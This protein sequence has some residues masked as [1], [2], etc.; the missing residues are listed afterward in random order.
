MSR[1]VLA[2]GLDLRGRRPAS[3]RLRQRPAGPRHP[4]GRAARAGRRPRRVRHGRAGAS[5]TGRALR[6]APRHPGARTA[7]EAGRGLGRA[8]RPAQ[9]RGKGPDA[10]LARRPLVARRDRGSRERR[11]AHGLRPLGAPPE[12]GPRRPR[13]AAASGGAPAQ[14]V[15]RPRRR[16]ARDQGLRR[17]GRPRAL[18]GL[19]PRSRDPGAGRG[20][21]AA[22]RALASP[23]SRATAKASSQSAR[24]SSSC[25][26]STA[27]P[28][29]W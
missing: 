8:A 10:A 23:G 12:P 7:V 18:D 3:L 1:R 5:R 24:P 14:L 15:R 17:P 13:L 20:A 19:G 26:A 28:G 16:R 9:P 2:P 4:A 27:P 21:P 25:S 6:P 22:A 29:A 11:P